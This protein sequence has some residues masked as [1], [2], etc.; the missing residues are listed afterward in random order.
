M[1]RKIEGDAYK[2]G[3]QRNWIQVFCNG[4]VAFQICLFYILNVGFAVDAPL[5]F[6][7]LHI[8]SFLGCAYLGAMACCNGKFLHVFSF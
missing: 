1:K 3:G 8:A 4:G 2:D 6:S 5:N 7:K